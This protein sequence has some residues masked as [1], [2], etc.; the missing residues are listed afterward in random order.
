MFNSEP[1]REL[2]YR[3]Y[4]TKP[5]V[6]S[7]VGMAVDD[8]MSTPG[9]FA[10]K[11]GIK[12]PY[13]LYCG[14]QESLKGTPLLLDYL[15][16][17]RS[18]T[19]HDIKLVLAGAGHVVV[20]NNIVDSVIDVGFLD[21]QEKHDAMAG[22]VAFCHPSVNESFGIVL[23]ESWLARTPAIVHEKSPAL[24][25]QCLKSNAGMWFKTYPDFE[26]ELLLLL[27]RPELRA[28]LGNSGR[29]YVLMEYS[30]TSI[31]KKLLESVGK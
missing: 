10:H 14:R 4:S 24:K 28:A 31:D 6:S 18:R 1:E 25:Y 17:F 30:R 12:S 15:E 16:A 13:L 11:R 2:A 19:N 26:E 27:T 3:L 23:L 7:V 20:P 8:F 29:E 5:T 22:A 9:V 21:E